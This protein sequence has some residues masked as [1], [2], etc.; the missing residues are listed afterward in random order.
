MPG[1]DGA[2]LAELF[3]RRLALD[4]TPILLER[5]MCP[6]EPVS[7]WFRHLA[8]MGRSAKTMRKY[9]YVAL[10][11]SEFL[12]QAGTD[13]VS[14]TETD[15]LEYRALRTREQPEPVAKTTWEAEATA[16]NRLYAWLVAEGYLLA[17]PWR[18]D[19]GRDSLRNGVTQDLRVR[20]MTLDQYRYFRDVGLAGQLPDGAVDRSF[21]GRFPH[22]SR[23]GVELGLLTGMRLGEWSTL[24][25]PELGFDVS[26][27]AGRLR[28]GVEI[29]LE[30]C[31]KFGRPRMVYAPRSALELVRTYM[32]LERRHIVTAAQATLARRR[33]E[34]FVV[35][36]DQDGR[37]QLRGVLDGRRVTR[38]IRHMPPELRKVTVMDTGDRLE[39]LAVFVGPGGT[40][41]HPSTWD[42]IRWRAWERMRLHATDSAAPVMPSHPWLFHDLRHTFALQ[43]LRFLM[44]KAAQ[45]G[46]AS[47]LPMSTLADHIAYN[48]LLEVQRRLGHASPA[49][50]Y[51]Y[52]RYLKDPMRE[53]D[54]AFAEWS[55]H[56]EATYAEI[57]QHLLTSGG[58]NSGGEVGGDAS[59]R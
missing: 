28:D 23:A 35:D 56:E 12:A 1:I 38:S 8:L 53:V 46:A 17:R 43:L 21:R 25:L 26:P 29:Q 41:P 59:Q 58:K 47:D 22:R 7:S 34:L 5:E 32:L 4:G 52:L 24:L 49:T 40:M 6:V 51:I 30:A 39:P 54:E 15:L 9:A 37:G 18:S 31:A 3:G 48:P 13:V 36:A 10:R 42:K 11:L 45:D 20:H 19:G 44:R 27:A 16:I 14:A 50:T 55:A 57:G 33:S 2:E